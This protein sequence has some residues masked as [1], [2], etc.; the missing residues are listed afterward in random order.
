MKT[1]AKFSSYQVKRVLMSFGRE[2]ITIK[3][4]GSP[5]R[6]MMNDFQLQSMFI[7]DEEDHIFSK[8]MEVHKKLMKENQK[9]MKEN[10]VKNKE[11]EPMKKTLHQLLRESH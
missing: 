5:K 7:E 4:L 9:A 2:N 6:D 11:V 1:G 10:K 8:L 3:A